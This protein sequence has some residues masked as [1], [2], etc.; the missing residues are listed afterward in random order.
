MIPLQND[1]Y[2]EK[3]DFLVQWA[4]HLQ[5]FDRNDKGAVVALQEAVHLYEQAPLKSNNEFVEALERL[6]QVYRE[7]SELLPAS[8]QMLAQSLDKRA[9]AIKRRIDSQAPAH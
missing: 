6:A 7:Q 1:V 4:K 5:Q 8:Y 9:Q 3:A 2:Q